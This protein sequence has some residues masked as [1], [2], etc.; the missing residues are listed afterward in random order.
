MSRHSASVTHTSPVPVP[1]P[2]FFPRR[3]GRLRGRLR[4][5][6]HRASWKE[7]RRATRPPPRLEGVHGDH[8]G[9]RTGTR[10]ESTGGRAPT[11]LPPPHRS[12][13]RPGT[14]SEMGILHLKCPDLWPRQGV[15][16]REHS[17][18]SPHRKRESSCSSTRCQLGGAPIPSSQ[19]PSAPARHSGTQ[20]PRDHRIP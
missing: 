19:L 2:G 11:P 7:V 15:R 10:E 16:A 20:S 6:R 18:W 1:G 5:P 4:S 17:E 9:Q 12:T 3:S 14:Q 13:H 8:G